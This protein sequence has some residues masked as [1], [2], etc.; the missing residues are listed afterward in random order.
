MRIVV[1]WNACASISR[2]EDARWVHEQA[3]TL[4]R[5]PGVRRLA[6]H[7]VQSAA[8]R[9]PRGWDWCLEMAVEDEPKTIVR[10]PPCSEWLA[11]LRLLGTKPSVFVLPEATA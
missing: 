10:T 11:D 6:I 2:E 9:H 5:A 1:L 4:S 7:E 8:A 3:A